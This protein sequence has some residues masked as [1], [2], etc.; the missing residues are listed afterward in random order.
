MRWYLQKVL[1]HLVRAAA[2]GWS[3][4]ATQQVQLSA[5]LLLIGCGP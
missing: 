5:G 4:L 2:E 3:V 1:L